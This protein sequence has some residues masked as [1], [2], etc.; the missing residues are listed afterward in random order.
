MWS[1]CIMDPISTK[2][3]KMPIGSSSLPTADAINVART[4]ND[5]TT[6]Q[7]RAWILNGRLKPGE[8]LHQDQLAIAL[9]VSR[10]P[11]R[12]AIRQLA[13]EGLVQLFP[14]RGAFVS[15]MD[16]DEIRE[17]YEVRAALEGLAISHAVPRVTPDVVVSLHEILRRLVD[18]VAA[19]DD[20][21]TI[22]FDRHLHDTLIAP[23]Q[24]PYLRELIEQARRRS[25]AFR[26]A[27]TYII[28][29]Q[30]ASSN[31]EHAAIIAAVECGDVEL[32]V[33]LIHEHLHNAATHLIT[34]FSAW[35][36]GREPAR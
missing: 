10:M 27:H 29:G 36:D 12:E 35:T 25:E 5:A 24:K 23:A 31:K 28:P 2:E 19:G 34:Y 30:S 32:S 22:E 18:A 6:G 16:P 13:A 9:G 14:H 21:A 33:Q 11:V 3:S 4:V 20:E 7:I 8:R 26:R 1:E 15:S 17:L